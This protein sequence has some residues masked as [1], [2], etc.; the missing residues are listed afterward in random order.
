MGATDAGVELRTSGTM[1]ERG[2]LRRDSSARTALLAVAL[3]LATIIVYLP[4][5]HQPFFNLDD[6]YYVVDN[7]HVH[8][9]NG[10]TVWWAFS[11]LS[12]A[13][14][15]P[16]SF[17]SHAVDW[18]LFGDNPSGHHEVNVVLHGL[19]AALLFWVLKRATGYTGRSFMVAALFALHPLNVEAVAWI[20]E[21]KTLLSGLF[22]VLALGAYDSYARQ[23]R[24]R[25]YWLVALLYALGLAAK[26]Q[27][28]TLPAVFL[29]WDFWPLQRM[30]L[31]QETSPEAK[32]PPV[33]AK[34]FSWLLL[35]KVPFLL[36]AAF[37]AMLTIYS[38]AGAHPR[39]WAP[40]SQRLA[41]A[42]F[43]YYEYILR[44]FWPINMAPMYPNRGATLGA[45]QVSMATVILLAITVLVIVGRRHRYLPVGWF[46]FL[47]TLVPMM[48]VFQFG[49]E[50]M[51]DRFAHEAM[52]GIF[53]IVC[54]GLPDLA[55]QRHLSPVWLA[56]GGAVAL[57]ALSLVTERQISY[58]NTPFTMWRHALAVVPNHW[59]AE[60]LIGKDL[61]LHGKM[62]EGV[63]HFRRAVAVN[64]DDGLGNIGIGLYEQEHGNPQEALAHYQVAVRDYGLLPHEVAGIYKNMAMVYRSMGDT[65]KE[66]ECLDKAAQYVDR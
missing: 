13:N 58:W 55:A 4:V 38:E 64:P 60:D 1:G 15:I 40:F 63:E 43:S 33:P 36:I 52:V 18:Q 61:M 10:T 7:P 66:R 9:L 34:P 24:E 23:P 20:A 46:W 29:L 51:A 26:A 6:Y 30:S 16:L 27:I 5:T 32:F 39:L 49:K 37:D 62:D 22:F 42:L 48:Q 28:I 59:M 31:G 17:L 12:M 14:W 19:T 54:W 50:G 11:N 21:R 41:N 8:Q 3:L 65:A 44:I 25:R 2:L 35:E 47:G 56:S 53:I 57:L 45:G